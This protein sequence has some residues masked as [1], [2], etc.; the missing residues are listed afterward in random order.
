VQ[1]A[2]WTQTDVDRAI[3][4]TAKEMMRP[5][6]PAAA[7]RDALMRHLAGIT[8]DVRE[9]RY[10]RMRAV[11]PTDARRALLETLDAGLPRAA[12]CVVSSREKLETANH[13][14]AL[15]LTIR[16]ILQGDKRVR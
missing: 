16:D 13:E 14:L 7:T 6:R 9:Q 11:T 12:T 5:I 15:P 3:I 4:A 10:A 1:S 8:R 2:V